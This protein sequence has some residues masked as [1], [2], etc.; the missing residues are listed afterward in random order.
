MVVFTQSDVGPQ[1]TSQECSKCGLIGNRNGKVF[2]CPHCD[3]ID[4]A[5]VNAAFNIT[6]HQGIGQSVADRYVTEGN[7]DIPKEAVL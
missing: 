7:T 1:Y 2:K 5:D 6:L 3:H 4:H